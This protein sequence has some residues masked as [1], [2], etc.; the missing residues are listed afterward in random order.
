MILWMLILHEDLSKEADVVA[1]AL[2]EVYRL[3]S[4]IEE[5]DLTTLFS[6]VPN[7]SN[8]YFDSGG[9]L[10]RELKDLEA[11]VLVLT[12]KDLYMNTGNVFNPEDDWVFGYQLEFFYVVS[13]AR[14]RDTDSKPSTEVRVSKELYHNRVKTV[15]LHEIGHNVVKAHHLRDAFW[16]NAQNGRKLNLGAHCT[17]YSCLMYESVDIIAPDPSL[18]YLEIGGEK[19]YDAGLDQLLQRMYPNMLCKPC[20]KSVDLSEIN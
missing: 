2:R 6:P 15:A 13:T 3:D 18:G 19:R 20:L 17:D 5:I 4:Q 14:L 10:Y 1:E 8:G 16:V 12:P 7:L 11:S 9:N